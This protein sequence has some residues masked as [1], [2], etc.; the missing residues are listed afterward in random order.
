MVAL[1][2]VVCISLSLGCATVHKVRRAPE[3]AASKKATS[4]IYYALPRTVCTITV[5]IQRSDFKPGP[6]AKDAARFG[7][8]VDTEPKTEFS[9]DV[10]SLQPYSERDPS[11][12]FMVKI[13]GKVWERRNLEIELNQAGLIVGS[14]ATVESMLPEMVVKTLETAVSV[15]GTLSG[16]LPTKAE[17]TKAMTNRFEGI[18]DTPQVAAYKRLLWLK[19]AR[20]RLIDGSEP[21]A[22]V[23]PDT[24]KA[25]LA[26]LDAQLKAQMELFAGKVEKKAWAAVYEVRPVA[27][28]PLEGDLFTLDKKTGFKNLA[29][30]PTEEVR[31]VGPAPEWASVG[32]PTT[33]NKVTVSAAEVDTGLKDI[34][35]LPVDTKKAQG[36]YYRVPGQG[37]VTVK[38]QGSP[39]F[40]GRVA[41]AQYG[42]IATLPRSTGSWRKSS[43]TT[44]FFP[45]SG[46][47]KKLSASGEPLDP[48]LVSRTL[49]AAGTYAENRREQQA[50]EDAAR[51]AR[52]QQQLQMLKDFLQRGT[53][54]VTGTG[55][56]AQ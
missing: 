55:S 56:A 27:G 48:E 49:T 5:P 54:T 41:I 25:A 1:V 50:A 9:H 13:Q 15:I 26:D 8:V 52:R 33:G 14:T 21:L 45:D 51:E 23:D 29:V 11:Q 28:K 12:L 17:G 2:M 46:S 34:I 20:D 19:A 40:S 4:G 31:P 30:G 47:M 32:A 36:F 24:Y 53:G 39:I 16:P 42:R 35:E 43:Y 6:F 37:D 3:V 38:E 10:P 18:E 7:L 44:E 22:S